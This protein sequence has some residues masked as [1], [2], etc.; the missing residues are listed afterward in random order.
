MG[1]TWA[2]RGCWFL[3]VRTVKHTA[4]MFYCIAKDCQREQLR[5][6]LF[7]CSD[8][9]KERSK[10]KAGGPQGKKALVVLEP[11]HL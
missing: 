9:M 3:G 8:F 10:E 11:F 5:S 4:G 6:A 1:R 2:A 7:F